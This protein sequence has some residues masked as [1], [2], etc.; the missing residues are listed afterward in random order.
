M[1]VQLLFAVFLLLCLLASRARSQLRSRLAATL[2]DPPCDQGRRNNFKCSCLFSQSSRLRRELNGIL[3]RLRPCHRLSKRL[4]QKTSGARCLPRLQSTCTLRAQQA[5]VFMIGVPLGPQFPL[6][7]GCVDGRGCS[8]HHCRK[9]V[10]LCW[11]YH[12]FTAAPPRRGKDS[13]GGRVQL[14]GATAQ[15]RLILTAGRPS[16]SFFVTLENLI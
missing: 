5:I 2:M 14:I 10:R 15:Q 9:A 3:L 12:Y 13:P 11:E 6:P 7:F 16:R 4:S 1:T 8:N